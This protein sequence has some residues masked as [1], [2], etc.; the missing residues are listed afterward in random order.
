M[1]LLLLSRLGI[2]VILG[3]ITLRL[4]ESVFFLGFLLWIIEMY[5]DRGWM[6]CYGWPALRQ[7]PIESLQSNEIDCSLNQAVMQFS[8]RANRTIVK[9]PLRANQIR[10]LNQMQ[11]LCGLSSIAFVCV[12]CYIFI[13]R[14]A[15]LNKIL[16]CRT[17]LISGIFS[18]RNCFTKTTENDQNCL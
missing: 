13:V 6:V 14:A 11:T 1:L 9:R 7:I 2:D 15:A 10:N 5:A 18:N 12:D 8:H 17:L 4:S 16:F 3:S